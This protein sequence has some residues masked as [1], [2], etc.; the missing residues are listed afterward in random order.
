MPS[1]PATPRRKCAQVAQLVED[2]EQT[3]HRDASGWGVP[4]CGHRQ[5]A[6]ARSVAADA[7]MCASIRTLG[8]ADHD[9]LSDRSGVRIGPYGGQV[10]RLA[11]S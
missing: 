5:F 9:P 10:A 6:M 1:V 8:H 4:Q 11:G 7:H 3:Q 2:R